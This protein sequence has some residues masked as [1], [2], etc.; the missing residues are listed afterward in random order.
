[1]KPC[2]HDAHFSDDRS[3]LPF[4]LFSEKLIYHPHLIFMSIGLLSLV[5]FGICL[6]NDAGQWCDITKADCTHCFCQLFIFCSTR[7]YYRDTRRLRKQ[8]EKSDL[9]CEHV[10]KRQ[11]LQQSWLDL[12]ANRLES[13]RKSKAPFLLISMSII[14]LSIWLRILR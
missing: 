4:S 11:E 1:M 14:Y 8:T 5:K 6:Q 9:P 10:S 2:W 3:N 12:P 13:N 7:D